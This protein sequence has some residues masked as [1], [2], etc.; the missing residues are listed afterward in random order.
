MNETDKTL[1]EIVDG[2][3]AKGITN[4]ETGLYDEGID[5]IKDQLTKYGQA[6]YER[7]VKIAIS[8]FLQMNI[9][10]PKSPVNIDEVKRRSLESLTKE[11]FNLNTPKDNQ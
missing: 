3:D 6:E 1:K 5:L 8:K 4:F 11:G 9:K 10:D 7:G 2:L